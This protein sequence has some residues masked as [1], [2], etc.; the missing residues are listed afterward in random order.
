MITLDHLRSSGFARKAAAGFVIQAGSRRL[1]LDLGR[2]YSGAPDSAQIG[3]VDAVIL[4][5]Q[6]PDHC[7]AID[8]L[9]EFGEPQLFASEPVARWLG[10]SASL[11]PMVGTLDWGDVTLTTGRNGHAP[12]GIWIHLAT[13][14]CRFLY[15]GDM[16]PDSAVF[17]FDPPPSADHVI[18][19]A[20]YGTRV[21]EPSIRAQL[22]GELLAMSL[23]L[24]LPAPATG[25]ALELALALRDVGC[26][27]ALCNRTTQ[28]AR[29]AMAYPGVLKA[30]ARARCFALL[31]DNPPVQPDCI[32]IDDPGLETEDA[33]SL[34]RK[35]LACG[36]SVCLTGYLPE[37]S[38]AAALCSQGKAQ[39]LGWPAHPDFRQNSDLI[40]HL[41][42][43]EVFP[44]FCSVEDATHFLDAIVTGT[45]RLGTASA[46]LYE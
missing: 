14:D 19:D 2:T 21:F 15:I 39:W 42:V 5:H 43:T 26:S 25:R 7:G 8:Q 18:V 33:R 1:L 13:N 44:A 9:S 40:R 22:L 41:G 10:L 23:P 30:E 4:T 6:H 32:L 24:V 11:L 31:S 3:S 35:S 34:V 20:S 16:V 12:G 37:E 36:G 29:D 27:V 17:P 46:V 28:A 45:L 38:E